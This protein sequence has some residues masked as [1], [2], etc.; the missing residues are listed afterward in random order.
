[1]AGEKTIPLGI[2]N[3]DRPGACSTRELRASDLSAGC[4]A[5]EW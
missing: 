2:L 4:D 1:M 3:A 5:A